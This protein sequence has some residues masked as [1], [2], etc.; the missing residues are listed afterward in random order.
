[1]PVFSNSAALQKQPVT[2]KRRQNT[3]YYTGVAQRQSVSNIVGH[4][5]D[6]HESERLMVIAL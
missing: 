1:L 4:I 5:L 3:A 6:S 2:A